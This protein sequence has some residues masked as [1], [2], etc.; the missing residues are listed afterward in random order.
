VPKGLATIIVTRIGTEQSCKAIGYAMRQV[1][2]I[3]KMR[4]APAFGRSNGKFYGVISRIAAIQRDPGISDSISGCL[5]TLDTGLYLPSAERVVAGLL[6]MYA[7]NSG[8]NP[9]PRNPK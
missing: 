4:S 3:G 7:Q 5:K 9:S 1:V 2:P 6:C 8:A